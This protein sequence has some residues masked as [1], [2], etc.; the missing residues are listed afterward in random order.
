[1]TKRTIGV[2]MLYMG[3]VYFYTAY[4][5]LRCKYALKS[6]ECKIYK[7]LLEAKTEMENPMAKGKWPKKK[8]KDED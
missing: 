1:M 6:A 3:L 4:V 2:T 7:S 8:D 5:D